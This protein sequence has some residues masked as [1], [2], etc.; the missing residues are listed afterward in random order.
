MVS[1]SYF[2]LAELLI[3]GTGVAFFIKDPKGLFGPFFI[4]VA[5]GMILDRFH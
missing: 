5:W 3:S 2:W 4:G 1:I